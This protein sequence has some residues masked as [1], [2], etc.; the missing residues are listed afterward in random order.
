MRLLRHL[1][2]PA[3]RGSRGAR[4]VFARMEEA[5]EFGVFAWSFPAANR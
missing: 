4:S 3:A 5:A 1:A 2:E